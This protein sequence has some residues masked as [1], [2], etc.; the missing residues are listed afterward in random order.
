MR[1]DLIIC[2][3]TIS[4]LILIENSMAADCKPTVS[5]KIDSQFYV[6][7]TGK[8]VATVN[9][10]CDKAFD[11]KTEVNTERTEGYIKVYKVQSEDDTPRPKTHI[12]SVGSPYSYTSLEKG[13]KANI[14][15]FI[16]PDELALAPGTYTLFENFYV[17]DELQE[18]KE[19]K[20][21]VSKS[22]TVSHLIPTQL[23]LNKPT[24]S[25][26]TINN[27]GT[28]IIN[29]LK[30][31]LSS[32][33]NVASFSETCKS[34]TNLPSKF[35][36]KF[37]VYING[38]VPGN[39]QNEIKVTTDYH[40]FTGLDVS[41]TYSQPSLTI[42]A[43]KTETP[44]LSYSVAK[45]KESITF[46]IENKGNGIAYDCVI[47]LASP[48]DCFINSS[49]IFNFTK[50]SILQ[51]NVNNFY[52]IGCSNLILPS[53]TPIIKINFDP[54]QINPPC[55]IS[56]SIFYKD[57]FGETRETKISKF[58]LAERVVTTIP[59]EDA[60]KGK[61]NVWYILIIAIVAIAVILV[62]FKIP[63]VRNF[64]SQK[65]SI[66]SQK[67]SKLFKKKANGE[68]SLEG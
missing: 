64:L 14:V 9:N 24:P 22:V 2:F 68:K 56:G 31:C 49:Q 58:N 66:I 5:W 18:S 11:V 43:I 61:N 47:N 34:W 36:D 27:M 55:T 51:P 45:S 41:D 44:E 30:V 8:L 50:A 40:T 1:K 37:I 29:S 4:F 12:T 16:Q 62:V 42:S 57:S 53:D 10:V 67:L 63:K 39:F 65:I 15:Y 32:I 21:T 13:E 20:I 23:Q 3:F 6:G 7:E 17:D 46:T 35:T 60:K 48:V 26:L 28:E 25:T 19:I 59:G 33:N 52:L 38:L 54:S